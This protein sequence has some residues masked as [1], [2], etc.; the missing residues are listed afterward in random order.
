MSVDVAVISV[1]ASTLLSLCNIIVP[2]VSNRMNSRASMKEK[3]LE[4]R[5]SD[6]HSAISDLCENYARMKAS[7]KG[8]AVWK[9]SA[10]I[11]RIQSLV[12]DQEVHV[13]LSSLLQSVTLHKCTS[14]ESE[15]FLSSALLILSKPNITEE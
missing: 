12:H 9:L 13:Y 15:E 8:D 14:S 11:Y 5:R 4:L 2:F 7:E 1:I 10:S 6:L 3:A